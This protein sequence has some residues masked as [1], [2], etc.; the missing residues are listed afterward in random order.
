MKP[1]LNG[2]IMHVRVFSLMCVNDIVHGAGPTLLNVVVI[3][4]RI[5]AST[6][7]I[8]QEPYH[9]HKLLNSISWSVTILF[10]I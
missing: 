6:H 4:S 7:S 5:C 9:L 8:S 2:G 10:M 3:D 1:L